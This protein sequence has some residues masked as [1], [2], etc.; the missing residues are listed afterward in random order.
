MKK[1]TLVELNFTLI[2]WF[3]KKDISRHLSFHMK[4]TVILK[5]IILSHSFFD[6]YAIF[7][8]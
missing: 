8:M 6:R 5:V 1:T 7:N 4:L 2:L 3:L